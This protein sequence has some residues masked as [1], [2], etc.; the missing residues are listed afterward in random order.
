MTPENVLEIYC[1]YTCCLDFAVKGNDII[2]RNF[3]KYGKAWILKK[4]RE[5]CPDW[6]KLTIRAGYLPE[7]ERLD[8]VVEA[9]N[10]IKTNREFI[11]LNKALIES[12]LS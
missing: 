7:H 12:K 2:V 8:K 11:E 10:V 3:K 4:L 5:Y 1:D 9:L 6:E